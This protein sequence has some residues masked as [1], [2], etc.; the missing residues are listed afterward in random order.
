ML[1]DVEAAHRCFEKAYTAEPTYIRAYKK[2]INL[3]Y[4]ENKF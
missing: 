4:S 2:R 3:F 1:N